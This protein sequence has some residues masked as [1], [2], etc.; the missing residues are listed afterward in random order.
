[1]EAGGLTGPAFIFNGNKTFS[2]TC[3]ES[4]GSDNNVSMHVAFKN[5][6]ERIKLRRISVILY[7]YMY[8][9]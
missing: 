6:F 3:L 5:S 8:T 9:K 4:Y 1:M 7:Q 2:C